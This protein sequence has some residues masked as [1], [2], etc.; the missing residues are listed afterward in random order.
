MCVCIYIYIE[1][2]R[3]TDRDWQKEIADDHC[4]VYLYIYIYTCVTLCGWSAKQT[5]PLSV[6][7]GN[8][9]KAWVG[10]LQRDLK[11]ARERQRRELE[12]G[13]QKR[14]LAKGDAEG[15]SATDSRRDQS[16]EIESRG[17]EE[18]R[19]DEFVALSQQRSAMREDQSRWV[20]IPSSFVEITRKM[21]VSVTLQM[22]WECSVTEPL[23]MHFELTQEH[24]SFVLC[25]FSPT[26]SVVFLVAIKKCEI[27]RRKP[28]DES[29]AN[30]EL[31]QRNW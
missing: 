27:P 10:D 13:T 1:R 11:W 2:E 29:P 20:G 6:L 5:I 31:F 22:H 21:H 18:D 19:Q 4:H 14:Q 30:T 16:G 15:Q 8:K 12:K 23:F 9:T 3:Q 26:P 24:S 28:L 25:S 17:S 7:A